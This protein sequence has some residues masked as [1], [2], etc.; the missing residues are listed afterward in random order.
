M[1]A[2][3]TKFSDLSPSEAAELR[4][5]LAGHPVVQRDAKDSG[6]TP[7][8]C[9]DYAFHC[10]RGGALIPMHDDKGTI[11]GF[12]PIADTGETRH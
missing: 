9:V 3:I 2:F 6:R 5:R 4:S 11:I 10:W 12:R 7:A 8:E 1:R